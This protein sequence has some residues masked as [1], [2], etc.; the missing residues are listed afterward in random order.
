VA[1]PAEPRTLKNV[2]RMALISMAATLV[3]F[4]QGGGGNSLVCSS[5]RSIPVRIFW[6]RRFLTSCHIAMPP[7]AA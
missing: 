2:P 3:S 4:T 7:T 6:L 1:W 5:T